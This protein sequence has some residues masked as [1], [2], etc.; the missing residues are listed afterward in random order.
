MAEDRFRIDFTP[1][2]NFTIG[3]ELEFQILDRKSLDLAPLA[4]LL[5]ENS[6]Q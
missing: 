3:V 4:P 2:N 6:P 5:L 1:N